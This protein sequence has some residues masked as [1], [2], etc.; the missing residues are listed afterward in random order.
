MSAIY[1]LTLLAVLGCMVLFDRRFT[2]FFWRDPVRAALVTGAGLAFFLLWD[3]LGISL[4][5]FFRA[6]SAIMTGILLAPEL[7]V[8]EVLFLIFLCYL[9]MVLLLGS[10]RM[11]AASRRV[12]ASRKVR[13]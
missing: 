11:F 2:L 6:E 13:R 10:E 12:A 4:G 5:I 8:E 3:V 1:L 9:T 7:P